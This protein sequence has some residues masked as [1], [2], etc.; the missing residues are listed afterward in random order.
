MTAIHNHCKTEHSAARPKKN[1][2]TPLDNKWSANFWIIPVRPVTSWFMLFPG[3]GICVA[4][5]LS[6]SNLE[7]VS[8]SQHACFNARRIQV[9]RNSPSTDWPRQR[10]N[11]GQ[12]ISI[13]KDY[14]KNRWKEWCFIDNTGRLL[15]WCLDAQDQQ[16]SYETINYLKPFAN[17]K[18]YQQSNSMMKL[19]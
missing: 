10:E 1:T 16:E 4:Y 15:R 19:F 12:C 9:P 7:A 5:G 3:N 13:P 14:I 18:G 17:I 6:F 11:A 2:T 8:W